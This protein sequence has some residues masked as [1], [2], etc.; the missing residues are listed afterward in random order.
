MLAA[1]DQLKEK[2]LS[3]VEH[4]EH[5]GGIG[6]QGEIPEFDY[7]ALD[8]LDF[9]ELNLRRYD[10]AKGKRERENELISCVS[11]LKRALDNQIECFL[12]SW[13]LRND[14]KKRNLGLDA[15]LKFL[16]DVGLFSSRTIGRFTTLRNRIEHEFRRPDVKDL[17]ALFDLVSA[18]VAI[19]QT[20]LTSGF[21]QELHFSLAP[22][23]GKNCSG[24]FTIQYCS[25]AKKSL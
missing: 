17:E 12:S 15:K 3:F 6:H 25:E 1:K 8:Y 16:S 21:Y 4:L 19:L 23:K 2:M 11:N 10:A 14:V 20:P 5:S 22:S 7:Y 13:N 24:H 18:L 9:A